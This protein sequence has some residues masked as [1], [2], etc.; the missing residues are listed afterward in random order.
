MLTFDQRPSLLAGDFTVG[1]EWQERGAE[2][3]LAVRE[4]EVRLVVPRT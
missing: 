4:A 1:V 2:A 3:P